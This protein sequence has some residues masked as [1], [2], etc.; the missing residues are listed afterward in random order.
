MDEVYKNG[1][2][3]CMIN[4][5]KYVSCSIPIGWSND[6]FPEVTGIEYKQGEWVY[7]P[8]KSYPLMCFKERNQAEI[9]LMEETRMRLGKRS[10][11]IVLPCVYAP[12]PIIY[13]YNDPDYWFHM[14]ISIW[15]DVPKGT[16]LAS[17]I[18]LLGNEVPF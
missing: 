6:R 10:M 12:Y 17:E 7:M 11:L 2:K 1:Y 15:G 14:Y 13:M 8:H 5:D 16:K 18:M 3:V 9:F 4:D